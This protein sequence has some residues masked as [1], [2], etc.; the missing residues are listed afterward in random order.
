MHGIFHR[1]TNQNDGHSLVMLESYFFTGKWFR[2]LACRP[3]GWHFSPFSWVADVLAL[4][5]GSF[6]YWNSLFKHDAQC[7][8]TYNVPASEYQANFLRFLFV[9]HLFEQS[10][11]TKLPDIA[12]PTLISLC[13]HLFSTVFCED[14]SISV[15]F[16]GEESSLPH[17]PCGS[18]Y[19]LKFYDAK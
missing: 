1:L 3:D 19:Q 2:R 7:L 11:N 5:A 18:V 4:L 9:C 10:I 16:C 14:I 8:L 17:C 13:M 6:S 12:L 15:S